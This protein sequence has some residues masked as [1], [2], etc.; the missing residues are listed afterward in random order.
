MDRR[1]TGPEGLD[2]CSGAI[3]SSRQVSANAAF[4]TAR[5]AD[6]TGRRRASFRPRAVG[7]SRIRSRLSAAVLF[8]VLASFAVRNP[9]VVN[10]GDRVL[11]VMTFFAAFLPLGGVWSLERL[12]HVS[13][14]ARRQG[15][16]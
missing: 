1:L 11:V 13:A 16:A 9:L 14:C 10:G 8:V 2:R 7:P 12:W 15:S 5:S 4:A 6:A 3:V